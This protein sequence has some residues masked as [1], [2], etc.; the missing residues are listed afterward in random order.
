MAA[1]YNLVID[2][3]TTFSATL[4]VTDEFGN[5]VDMGGYEASGQLRKVYSSVNAVSFE[6]SI[7]AVAGEV[8]IGLAANTTSTMEDGRYVYDVE[9]TE[10]ETGEVSRIIEGL[11]TVTPSVTR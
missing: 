3:G 11:V 7:N 1:K 4:N 5:A 6:C 10:T 9:I 2:Q 8:T